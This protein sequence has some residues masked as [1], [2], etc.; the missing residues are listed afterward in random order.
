[1][2]EM[3]LGLCAQ[4]AYTCY[5]AAQ[6]FRLDETSPKLLCEQD[7]STQFGRW[8]VSLRTL[9]TIGLVCFCREA[10][11]TLRGAQDN[12]WKSFVLQPAWRNVSCV[13]HTVSHR[14]HQEE[15]IHSKMRTPICEVRKRTWMKNWWVCC[16]YKRSAKSNQALN[17]GYVIH[18]MWSRNWF[19]LAHC[20][21]LGRSDENQAGLC[22]LVL[23]GFN[24]VPHPSQCA[25]F[26]LP[27]SWKCLREFKEKH[28]Y[29]FSRIQDAPTQKT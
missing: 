25:L 2:G 1:M 16:S 12:G 18:V 3:V 20:N 7:H 29:R 14:H 21:H 28:D 4:S 26:R 15:H 5:F 8:N 9:V 24:P 10:T 27:C 22:R 23:M 17:S 13:F 19:A 6:W 11:F